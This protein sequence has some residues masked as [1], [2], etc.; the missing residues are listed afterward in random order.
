[1]TTRTVFLASKVTPLSRRMFSSPISR[2][3]AGLS[4]TTSN[5][6]R[7]TH[8]KPSI[9]H[10]S[11]MHGSDHWTYER[12]FSILTIPILGS[13]IA[14]GPV[15]GLDYALG[16]IVPIHVHMGFDTMIQDYVPARKYTLANSVLSWTLTITTGLVA[17]SLYTFNT[18]DVGVTAFVQ[19]LWTGDSTRKLRISEQDA[20]L[21]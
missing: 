17:Y 1:M 18:V 20:D 13:A 10:K 8:P 7:Q 14:F 3:P 2:A 6:I 21:K 11:K 5:S 4:P 9:E 15:W 16:V 19:R 12:Y